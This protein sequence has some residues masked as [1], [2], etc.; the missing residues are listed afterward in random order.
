MKTTKFAEI[1]VT[2]LVIV[3]MVIIL[4]SYLVYQRTG[5]FGFHWSVIRYILAENLQYLLW[6]IIIL[7]VGIYFIVRYFKKTIAERKNCQVQ[8]VDLATISAKWVE[9][10]DVAQVIRQTTEAKI[11]SEQSK[12]G[13]RMSV[14]DFALKMLHI[15]ENRTKEFIEKTIYPIIEK[16]NT[17]DMWIIV[18]LILLLDQ[19]GNIP[20][21]ASLYKQDPEKQMYGDKV[22]TTTGKTSY[23]VL[24]EFTLLDHT[25]R[26]AE[27]AL[28]IYK[29]NSVSE[30]GLSLMFGRI[31]IMSLAHD[32]GKIYKFSKEEERF[33]L[34][35]EMYATSP[36][37]KISYMMFRE[38]YPDYPHINDIVNAIASHHIYKVEGTLATLLKNA[39]ISAREI[40]INIWLR[41]NRMAIAEQMNTAIASSRREESDINEE[42]LIEAEQATELID[43][44]AKKSQ[45]IVDIES[46][47]DE[48]S[49]IH[50]DEQS[51]PFLPEVLVEKTVIQNTKR[52]KSFLRDKK[53]NVIVHEYDFI[54][55]HGEAIATALR[56]K[57]NYVDPNMSGEGAIVSISFE[58]LVLYNYTFFRK[59]VS[60][61]MKANADK[62]V[63][64]KLLIQFKDSGIARM[65]EPQS[66][67]TV[68]K[69]ILEK[70]SGKEEHSFVP[71]SCEFLGVT[72]QDLDT[73]KRENPLL[74][75]INVMTYTKGR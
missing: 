39:D 35:P 61:V 60:L 30:S 73:S 59:V 3:T 40:E 47:N 74:R 9:S 37:E 17:V 16:I 14:S 62:S 20:S 24:S 29:N 50:I 33:S 43:S 64:E 38:V 1:F 7:I 4:G 63:I 10:K 69:F 70:Q 53:E 57:I 48:V 12:N 72:Q 27:I 44:N 6:L 5:Y 8:W 22:I 28:D 25:F 68:S 13:N 51:E 19:C 58:D 71:I 2:A 56:E 49:A 41:R 26:V 23:Q 15:K 31:L 65:L 75:T 18:D 42:Y 66:G 67:Y 46:T 11:K 32:I 21:V 36:H 55:A 45:N 54:Q 34:A 52:K